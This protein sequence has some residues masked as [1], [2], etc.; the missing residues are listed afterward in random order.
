VKNLCPEENPKDCY[1]SQT[2][3]RRNTTSSRRKSL[4]YEGAE[5]K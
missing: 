3:I 2:K 1:D 4:P 5:C